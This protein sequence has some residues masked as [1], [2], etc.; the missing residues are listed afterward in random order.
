M[1]IHIPSMLNS[2][3][4]LYQYPAGRW[5]QSCMYSVLTIR[6]YLARDIGLVYSQLYYKAK[7]VQ[8]NNISIFMTAWERNFLCSRICRRDERWGNNCSETL[9]DEYLLS[10]RRDQK[11][12]PCAGNH[13]TTEKSKWRTPGDTE[14]PKKHSPGSG[15][16]NEV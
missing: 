4:M 13:V 3:W 6:G 7:Y 11:W 9:K 1:F 16:G 8:A 12:I 15:R 14:Q 10:C 5:L 2:L